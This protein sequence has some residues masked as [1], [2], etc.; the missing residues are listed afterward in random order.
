MRFHAFRPLSQR[1]LFPIRRGLRVGGEEAMQRHSYESEF[2][3]KGLVGGWGGAIR[4]MLR[5]GESSWLCM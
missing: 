3:R 4:N 2:G 5:R 1:R